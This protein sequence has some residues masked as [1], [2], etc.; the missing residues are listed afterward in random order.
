MGC[1]SLRF[2]Q[3][4]ERPTVLFNDGTPG[5]LMGG[6]EVV[7][8]ETLLGLAA[9]G[10]R[11]LL[12]YQQWGDLIPEYEAAGIECRQFDFA[13]VRLQHLWRFGTSIL[14]QVL[15]ARRRRVKLF[16]CNS[17]F[18]AAHA[19]AIKSFGGFPALCHFHL[20]APGYLS[21]QY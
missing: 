9:R 6:E 12:A 15:W 14:Q 10:F 16:Y 1:Q 19:A 18:R 21:R 17:Y 11:C 13:A 7:L 3:M 4:T 20:P 8:R 2:S 5:R